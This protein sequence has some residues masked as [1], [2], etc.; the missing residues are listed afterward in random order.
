[1]CTGLVSPEAPAVGMGTVFF[2][3]SSR[4]HPSVHVCV[5]ISSSKNTGQIGL[6]STQMNIF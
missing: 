1:M 6:G 5:L 4:G 2:T 3:A